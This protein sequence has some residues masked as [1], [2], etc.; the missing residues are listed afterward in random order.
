MKRLVY[1]LALIACP[2]RRFPRRTRPERST[3][4]L[5]RGDPAHAE[6]NDDLVVVR[7]R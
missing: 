5:E 1:W 2:R 3:P 7:A 4:E 6:K